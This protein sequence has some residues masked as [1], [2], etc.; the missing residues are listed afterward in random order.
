VIIE[1]NKAMEDDPVLEIPDAVRQHQNTFPGKIFA[2]RDAY[3]KA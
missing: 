2:S 1:L 3:S